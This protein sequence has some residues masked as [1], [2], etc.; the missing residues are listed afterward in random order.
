MNRRSDRKLLHFVV[1]RL[2]LAIPVLGALIVVV[3]GL[4]R[5]GPSPA[6]LIAGPLASEAGIKAVEDE[7]GF[8]KPLFEQF[9]TYVGNLF[10]G[11]W[12][13]SWTTQKD[14]IE[15]VRG[16][17]PITLE[18]VVVSMAISIVFGVLL[19]TWVSLTKK[20]RSA[21][22]AMHLLGSIGISVPIFWLALLLIYF[23]YAILGV[24]P[25]PIGPSALLSGSANGLTG[26]P[27]IDAIL[28]ADLERIGAVAAHMA[29]PVATIVVVMGSAIAVQT[30]A[31]ID[32]S[33]LLPHVRY[34]EATGVRRRTVIG[35][36]VRN[37][38]PT[39]ITFSAASFSLIL[40][41]SALVEL[42]FSWGGLGQL[43]LN[44]MLKSDFALVQG[45]V[46][47]VGLI[48]IAVYFFTDIV[49]HLMDRRAEL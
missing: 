40:G 24:A 27:L 30:Q 28:S 18:L 19:G 3:F 5:I 48:T 38:A 7:Y 33:R 21:V 25:P 15:V 11:D 36:I 41:S 32:E 1:R 13:Y 12:G 6:S 23:F 49:V 35:S 26:A 4:V 42:V 44:A 46:L 9:L 10:R 34:F 22:R 47:V 37:A 45:F 17:L 16:G 31:A 8:N 29:L 2:T 39:F 20:N 43:G 14:V